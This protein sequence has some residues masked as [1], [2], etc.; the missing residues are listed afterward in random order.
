MAFEFVTADAPHSLVPRY[1]LDMASCAVVKPVKDR[2][3]APESDWT[4]GTAAGL[5]R[6]GAVLRTSGSPLTRAGRGAARFPD[7]EPGL[8]LIRYRP[9]GTSRYRLR[10]ASTAMRAAVPMTASAAGSE[11]GRAN[12]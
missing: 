8:A 4:P 5:P 10:S 11:I 12:V 3:D 2:F 9:G 6:T 1:D 7:R